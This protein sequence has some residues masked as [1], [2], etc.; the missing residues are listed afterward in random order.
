MSFMIIMTKYQRFLTLGPDLSDKL[1]LV[2]V[3]QG[4]TCLL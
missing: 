1:S 3:I 2:G 4:Q